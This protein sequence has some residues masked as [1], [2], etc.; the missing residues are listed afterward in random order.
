MKELPAAP[1]PP[2]E[3]DKIAN[4]AAYA[5]N[6]TSPDDKKLQLAAQGEQLIL[7]YKGQRVI[8]N[9]QAGIGS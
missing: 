2:P 4:A 1:P 3:P 5:G 7:Q 8:L 6:Y 9:R